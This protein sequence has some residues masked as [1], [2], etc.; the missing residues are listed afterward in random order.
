MSWYNSIRDL[1]GDVKKGVVGAGH[2][3]GSVAGNPLVDAGLGM[4][5]GPEAAAAA[6]GL[7][8]L[9]APG[10]NIG[11]GLTGAAIGGAAGYGGQMLGGVTGI[12]SG[13][14]AVNAASAVPGVQFT[15]SSM[16][17][18]SS[19][20]GPGAAALNVGGNAAS[21]VAQGVMSRVM[22]DAGSALKGI[23]SF[24]KN[25]HELLT[26]AGSLASGVLGAQAQNRQGNIAQQ[27][28]TAESAQIQAAIDKQNNIRN[29]FQQMYGQPIGASHTTAAPAPPVAASANTA[30]SSPASA[31]TTDPN[32]ALAALLKRLGYQ[33]PPTDPYAGNASQYGSPYA[34][35]YAP[36]AGGY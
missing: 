24:V 18:L 21:P 25:N 28:A 27:Q 5:F 23:P 11:R 35:G 12:G 15:P 9:M 4:F 6:G 26:T 36:A 16:E 30:P 31:V 1:E 20:Q 14:S 3:I 7:G 13:A 2:A 29:A 32:G 17:G 34:S 19:L 22:G 33:A 8:R 10:G